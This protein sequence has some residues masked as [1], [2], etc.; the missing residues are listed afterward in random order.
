MAQV[1]GNLARS[2]TTSDNSV[3][4]ILR[5]AFADPTAGERR[6]ALI[7]TDPRPLSELTSGFEAFDALANQLYARLDALVVAESAPPM[8]VE[9]EVQDVDEA[10]VVELGEADT[11]DA[12]QQTAQPADDLPELPPSSP[13]P[14]ERIKRQTRNAAE[15]RN[16]QANLLYEDVIWL[17]SMNDGQGALISLERLIVLADTSGE[18]GEFLELNEK[19]LLSLYEGFIGP[20]SKTPKLEKMEPGTD[21]P[22]WYRDNQKISKVMQLVNGKRAIVDLMRDSPY[23]SL[24]TCCILNQL[25]RSALV[26][27]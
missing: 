7:E 10:Q 20:F 21:M 19:K 6:V 25:R 24:Q 4:G 26:K 14:I 3:D 17:L 8:P 22:A 9:Q 15:L 2:T 18:I 13:P 16:H 5:I 12:E 23:S 1:E 11:S 27:I